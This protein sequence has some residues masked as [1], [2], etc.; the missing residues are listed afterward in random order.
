MLEDV[1]DWCSP[2][3]DELRQGDVLF[4]FPLVVPQ[5]DGSTVRLGLASK[6]LI[7]LTQSCDLV[8]PGTEYLQVA[9]LSRYSDLAAA[10]DQ[11]PATRYK[12]ALAEGTAIAEFLIPPSQPRMPNW[13]VAGFRQVF[14]LP[15]EYVQKHA[16]DR[17]ELVSPYREYLAQSY[18]RFMMRI[19]LPSGL[20]RFVGNIS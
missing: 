17:L 8:K 3:G 18:A 1:P 16:S 4:S 13:M 19:G 14:T 5:F 10:E 20:Q 7:I 9:A 11:Y 15:M 2:A 6:D 12:K